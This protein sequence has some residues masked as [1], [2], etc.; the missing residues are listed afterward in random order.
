MFVLDYKNKHEK[1]LTNLG[2]LLI[3]IAIFILVPGFF[4]TTIIL[5]VFGVGLISVK[6]KFYIDISSKTCCKHLFIFSFKIPLKLSFF[7]LNDYDKA[8]IY[9]YS[10]TGNFQGRVGTH[11][12]N[13]RNYCIS[14][15]N[16]DVIH[17]IGYSTD[18]KYSLKVL[19][20]LKS[21]LNYTIKNEIKE[22][23]DKNKKIRE[24]TKTL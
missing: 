5:L 21:D 7:D 10:M 22:K 8:L 15:Y 20:H 17:Q 4:I 6:N 24:F 19:N 23:L 13:S 3:C 18:Y 12:V 2:A 11:S 14:I 1:K 9:Q 16:K